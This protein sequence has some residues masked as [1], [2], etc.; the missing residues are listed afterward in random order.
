MKKIFFAIILVAFA[1][2][3]AKTQVN[4]NNGLVVHYTLD[5]H[6]A[7]SSSNGFDGTIVGSP[8]NSVDR[9]GIPN[10]A[11]KFDG[12]G[13]AIMV[14][15]NAKL[16]LTKDKSISVWYK[17]ESSIGLPLYPI[18]VYKKGINDY[19]TFG[20]YLREDPAYGSSRRKVSFI[21]GSGTSTNKE[22]YTTQNYTNYVNQWVH[23][24][25]THTSADGYMRIFFNGVIS[26]S[27]YVGNFVSN[28]ST[29]SLAIGRGRKPYGGNNFK[30]FLDDIRIYDRALSKSEIDVLYHE[31]SIVYN[32]L[33]KT[34]CQGDSVFAQGENR[35][36]AGTYYD[37]ISINSKLDSVIVTQLTV[38]PSYFTAN[39]K[40]I[41][42]GDSI[43]IAGA[44]RKSAGVYQQ[45]LNTK[46]GC[47][48]IIETT[49]TVNPVFFK[50]D[51]ITIC[52]GDSAYIAGKYYYTHT[53]VIQNFNTSK[54]CDSTIQTTLIV[55]PTHLSTKAI[56]LCSGDSVLI[57][58]NYIKTMGVYYDTLSTTNGCDSIVVT[59]V[60]VNT[61]NT[62]VSQNAHVLIAQESGATYQ[63]L[64]CNNANDSIAGETQQ[65]FI[66][67]NNGNYAVAISKNG[68]TDTSVCYTVNT[69]AVDEVL[70]KNL[71]VYPNPAKDIF[72]VDLGQNYTLIKV[73]V[74]TITGKIL[75]VYTQNNSSKIQVPA[76]QLAAGIYL[77]E[78]ETD[79]KKLISKIIIE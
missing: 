50:A 30:G 16:N 44:Y 14:P 26:D 43:F 42:F 32:Y 27:L 48:S 53:V 68:C 18:I 74:T 37:T 47:D 79:G 60:S 52:L 70:S 34:I 64:D 19:P 2:T 23:I 41:C 28:T 51:T 69:L 71:S 36:T 20:L 11:M 4:L 72:T 15:H 17:I 62:I 65:S 6:A 56:S 75:S 13:D 49:L 46:N 25:A 22:N 1:F 67:T 45:N 8:V 35:G 7:D 55:N 10:M 33:P 61:I 40:A 58:S 78:V 54:G 63:W 38:N 9:N 5:G 24:V 21:Q 29:D 77:L 73:A 59:T 76:S 66:A 57:G 3:A 12:I 31:F 39:T